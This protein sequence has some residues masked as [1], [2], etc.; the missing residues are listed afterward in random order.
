MIEYEEILQK[1]I[2]G[3]GENDNNKE[4]C[5]GFSYPDSIKWIYN[6]YNIYSNLART[7]VN[8]FPNAKTFLELGCGPGCLSHFIRHYGNN[9]V[10]VTLDINKDTPE[11]SKYLDHN[12]F[13]CFTDKPYQLQEGGEDAKFDVI[14]SYEHFEHIPPK[15]LKSFFDNIKNHC[16]DNTIIN[17]TASKAETTGVKILKENQEFK[18]V[19]KHGFASHQSVFSREEWGNI[20]DKNGFELLEDTYINDYNKPPNFSLRA[21]I[22]LTFKL[23]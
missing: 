3:L 10:T 20:L 13:L 12:H 1:D 15:N 21:T 9:V 4:E 8:E 18:D 14:I 16:H 19:P 2:I 5:P 22:E 17:A 7:L 6:D 23:K 11:L